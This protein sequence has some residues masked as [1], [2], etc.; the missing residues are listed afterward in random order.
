MPV[1]R[2]K[3]AMVALDA[4]TGELVWG[5]PVWPDCAVVDC[6]PVLLRVGGR[7][8]A[9]VNM[10]REVFAVD[11]NDGSLA[12]KESGKTATM[13]TPVVADGHVFLDIHE[14]LTQLKPRLRNRVLTFEKVREFGGKAGLD[15]IVVMDG[16]LYRFG[17]MAAPDTSTD[18]VSTGKRSRRKPPRPKPA[19]VCIDIESGRTLARLPCTMVHRSIIAAG[20]QIY[21]IETDN[22][23]PGNGKGLY[24]EEGLIRLIVPTEGGMRYAG[25]LRPAV[26]T[27]E[28]YVAPTIAEGRLFHRHGT[29]LVVYDLR[30]GSYDSR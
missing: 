6:S 11:I 28:I 1:R 8:F 26:G 25:V 15:Q 30:P 10:H 9:L 20:K 3:Y 16:R 14:R 18:P 27:K 22:K 23:A 5:T 7:Q 12:W 4:G 29:V 2:G 24:R 19:V 17:A 13:L 21:T